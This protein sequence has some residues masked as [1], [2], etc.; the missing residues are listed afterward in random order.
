MSEGS[1]RYQIFFAELK[2]RHVFKVTTVYGA[3]AFGVLQAADIAFPRMGL[4]DWTVTLVVALAAAGL[5]IA[6]V[7]AWAYETTPEGVR[8]TDPVGRSELE[9]IAALPRGRRWPIGVL[10]LVVVTLFC[11]GVWWVLRDAD[12]LATDQGASRLAP[13]VAVL[14]F[15]DLSG[16]ET[17]YLGD[18][19]AETLIN[20][21]TR[22]PGLRVTARTSA[23]AFK[24]R[25]EDVRQIGDQLG[26]GAVLEGSVQTSGERIRVTA[27][28]INA[29]DG[30][31]LWSNNFD[32]D[33]SDVFAVQDEVARA[34]VDALQVE[35]MERGGGSI[36]E[37]GTRS[38]A[39][40]NAYLKGRFYWNERTGQD[41][42]RAATYFEEAIA[43]DSSYALAW[44]GLADTYLLYHPAEYDVTVIPWRE[45]LRRAEAA[46]RRALALEDGL[47]EAHTS[48]GAILEKRG[49]WEE[50]DPQFRRALESN[51]QYATA[52]QWYGTYL[53][54]LG[55][56]EEALAQL[57][58]AAE[59]D[60]LSMVIN[61]EVA[62]VLDA[63]GR[64]DEAGAQVERMVATYPDAELVMY[65]A[66]LHYLPLGDFE[67][68]SRIASESLAKGAVWSTALTSDEALLLVGADGDPD[69]SREDL[70]RL[71]GS[72]RRSELAI[73]IY[74]GLGQDDQALQALESVAAVDSVAAIQYIPAVM[75]TLGPDLGR[76]P[77]AQAAFQRLRAAG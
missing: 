6:A 76:E 55:H 70:I 51:P 12:R 25:N 42:I 64:S 35:L 62:E 60:P 13:S 77:R 10:A 34:V 33:A 52:R 61:I 4:P 44:S 63:L 29:A 59:L 37:E 54:S 32:R 66:I 72:T 15:V 26:V 19:I 3:V 22:V 20:A 28:L 67:R 9:A 53:L 14:P 36:V 46:A 45:S 31:H 48:L 57:Q 49:L 47:A 11:A 5:P 43:A 18:G 23:F 71:A 30:F 39:A 27:Q 58:R 50:A 75:M 74:R 8:R 68:V 56:G 2:R 73:G 17:E 38:L 1:K 16:G 41:L 65:Y 69:G 40:Y 7:L 21:L 24:G